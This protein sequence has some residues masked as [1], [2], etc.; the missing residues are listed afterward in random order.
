MR[1]SL[2]S[3]IK[4]KKRWNLPSFL[5]T[6]P[7]KQDNALNILK[8]GVNAFLTW[9]AG[10]GKT[11]V[12]NAYIKYLKERGV[13]VA[14]TASTG[15][16]ATHIWGQTIHSWSGIGIKDQ[17]TQ[18]DLVFIAKRKK[19]K[20]HLE[21]T[22][23]LIID[24]IS[25]LSGITL[26]NINTV[27]QYFKQN[28]EPFGG[29]QVVFSG[30]FFQLPPIIKNMNKVEQKFAFMTPIWVQ[31][32]LTI[33]Y[34]TDQYRQKKQ[35]LLDNT[36][37][38]IRSGDK[39]EVVR[40]QLHE[41]V[42][43][44][45]K[46]EDCIKL[47]THNTQADTINSKHLEKIESK[48]CI[49]H[50]ETHGDKAIVRSL[51]N[52]VLAPETLKLKLWAKVM[53]VRNKPESGYQNGTLGEVIGFDSMD[54]PIV[55][56]IDK[57]QIIVGPEDWVIEDEWF[58]PIASY[59]QIPL[60][61]AWAITI[62]KSQ[63]M[64]L[65]SAH[66]DLSHAFEPGQGYVALSRVRDWD[67]LYLENFN[68]IALHLDPLAMKADTRFGELSQEH[69]KRFNTLSQKEKDKL[70]N[71]FIIASEWTTDN[72]IIKINKEELLKEKKVATEK[73]KNTIEQTFDLI[74]SGLDIHQ[75]CEKRNLTLGTILWHI[76]KL[77]DA[78]KKIEIELPLP[79]E[80]TV[81]EINITIDEILDTKSADFLDEDGQVKL[82]PLYQALDR[83]YSYE[84]LKAVRLQRKIE[85][86]K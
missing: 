53:F 24:E 11:Y 35:D 10:T 21:E 1:F 72:D 44:G 29:M 20:R 70:Q 50:A 57:K 45:V 85:G 65:N 28:F 30:D 79:D 51:K 82:S 47:I 77:F 40:E 8:T 84:D 75:I 63:G 83:S 7:M 73:K 38:L 22:K 17:I 67:G 3:T 68:E 80:H 39:M 12:L 37:E 36:L 14:V 62:H 55:E 42:I 78:W 49:Y 31:S 25:M 56:T 16:A 9:S 74:E 34:L 6:L 33:C 43:E 13:S 23:V 59:T 32:D 61:L 64:T 71:D 58:G 5:Y 41:K 69:E 86:R 66:I 18:R 81:E 48:E 19:I 76:E 4:H 54:F 52:S 46:D 60:R 15:I 27:C 2:Y 26:E